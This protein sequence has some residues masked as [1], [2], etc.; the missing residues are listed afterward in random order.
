MR[1]RA[2]RLLSS[3]LLMLAGSLFSAKSD[4]VLETDGFRYVISAGGQ[5]SAFIDKASGIDY[6]DHRRPSACAQIRIGPKQFPATAASRTNDLITLSFLPSPVIVRLGTTIHRQHIEIKIASVAGEAVD[7]VEF[8]HLP[9]TLNGKPGEPFAACSFALNTFTEVKELPA[10]QSTLTAIGH[11][12]FG[13][14]GAAAALVGVAEPAM[15]ATLRNIVHAAKDLPSIR[16]AGAWAQDV[17]F[18]HGSYLFNF[19]TLT[20]ATV[21]EWIETT[22]SLGF[23]QIDNHGGSQFFRFGDLELN[24]EKW[25]QGWKTYKNIVDRLHQAGIGSILHTYAFFIDKNSRYV[26]P[27]PHPQLDAFRTFTLAAPVSAL[28]DEIL[29]RESTAEISTVT[30]FF[31]HNSVTLHIGDELITFT[32]VKKTPPWGFTGCRRGACGT[33]AGRHEAGSPARHLKECFG[34]LVPDCESALFEEI[35]KRHA[36]IVD[37]C[38]FDGFYLDAIDGSGI[39]RGHD[40]A[41]YWGQRFVFLIYQHL[42]KPVSLELSSMWHQMWNFRSRWQAWDYPSRGHKRFIDLHAD[43]VHSG[44]LLPMHLGWWNF[45]HFSPP[46][47]EPCFPDVIDYLGCRLLGYDAGLSLTGSVNRDNLKKIPLYRR[48][49]ERLKIYEE[50]RH[51]ANL[52][53]S[54]RKKLRE[55]GKEHTLFA[56]ERG[57][58]GFKQVRYEKHKVV[59]TLWSKA[60]QV[61]NPFSDQ[62]LRVR[63]E[64][65]MSAGSFDDPANLVLTDLAGDTTAARKTAQGISQAFASA[66]VTLPYGWKGASWSAN[67]SGAIEQRAAWAQASWTFAPCL[68]S[69][70]RQAIGVWIHGDGNGEILN[71]RMES[72][73]HL[74][75]GAVADRYVTVDFSGWRY[76]ELIETESTRWSDY[77]WDDGKSLY[78]VYRENI[79][80]DA[81]EKFSL[82]YN[83]LPPGKSVTCLLSPIKAIPMVNG[84]C[85]N[86]ELQVNGRTVMLPVNMVSGDVLEFDSAEEC[87]HYSHTGE[88]KGRV[89]PV[90]PVPTLRNGLNDISVKCAPQ[91]RHTPRMQVTTVMLGETL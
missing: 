91:D 21:D 42:Q 29:V 53:E 74:A 80:F 89:R 4:V 66:K 85:R 49:V 15:L 34:L 23:N 44:L 83:N 17:D 57:G 1:S 18:N 70:E 50:L 39:L 63:I 32:G 54:I 90:G 22:K 52:D 8:I 26:T 28:A 67:N 82:W 35:A 86:I 59:D 64:A 68:N 25:P 84:T 10:L 75:Y 5:N 61:N 58:Y 87:I 30:G 31:V 33:K 71:F 60:W 77:I 14:S 40:E 38:G 16:T 6:C 3:W 11:K 20:E 73:E 56:D 76:L 13:L 55:P 9:L 24:R 41:W 65:L 7:A 78:N 43:A 88:V 79:H 2:E 12:R 69:R 37:S 62:P 46:Q 27:V 19:G 51:H 81:I 36:E 45:Q 72:P 48:L 47:E